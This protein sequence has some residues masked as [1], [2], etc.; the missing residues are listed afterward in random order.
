MAMNTR[1]MFD[2]LQNLFHSEQFSYYKQMDCTGYADLDFQLD[3]CL[4]E[5]YRGGIFRVVV[6]TYKNKPTSVA[7][8]QD[9]KGEVARID[10]TSWRKVK[11][12]V[13]PYI[14]CKWKPKRRAGVK[15]A[16]K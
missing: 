16:I 8:L 3:G 14:E 13:K 2:M 12:F 10:T 4:Y 7:F 6:D 9:G 1:E 11:E 5:Q 15:E